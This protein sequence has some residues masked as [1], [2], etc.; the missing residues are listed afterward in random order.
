M[1]DI[2]Q[3]HEELLRLQSGKEPQLEQA[4]FHFRTIA[5]PQR[6]I[7]RGAKDHMALLVID[8]GEHWLSAGARPFVQRG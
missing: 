2:E 6:Q 3:T 8:G 4:D 5:Q 7:V 1:D